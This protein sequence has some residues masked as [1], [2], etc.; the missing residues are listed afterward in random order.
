MGRITT[1]LYFFAA[2]S[3]ASIQTQILRVLF[4]RFRAQHDNNHIEKYIDSQDY[5]DILYSRKV[6]YLW[7]VVDPPGG[8]GAKQLDTP[9]DMLDVLFNEVINDVINSPENKSHIPDARTLTEWEEAESRRQ[10]TAILEQVEGDGA[11]Y[12]E[13]L[14]EYIQGYQ[15]GCTEDG[16][17]C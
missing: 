7:I 13:Y 16:E 10:L 5:F 17:P 3:I 2:A 11:E 9:E 8:A 6:G 15:E 4:I 14:D 12:L 1:L